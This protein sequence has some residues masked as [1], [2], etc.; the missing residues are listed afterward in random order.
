MCH[1][2]SPDK[3]PN[4][5][6]RA[7]WSCGLYI[8][9]WTST[10][11]TGWCMLEHTHTH[12]QHSAGMLPL[13]TGCREWME[14]F[15]PGFFF[16]C[17]AGTFAAS[18]L[19]ATQVSGAL[20]CPRLSE[21]SWKN[22]RQRLRRERVYT[23]EDGADSCALLCSLSEKSRLDKLDLPPPPLQLNRTGGFNSKYTD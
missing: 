12:T 1:L 17:T 2:N 19:Q 15:F 7:I 5:H 14:T 9:T 11:G 21:D 23:E 4:R 22:N 6:S 8:E 18:S 10:T 3:S 16:F 20:T 13:N